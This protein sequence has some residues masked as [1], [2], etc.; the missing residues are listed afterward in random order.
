VLRQNNAYKSTETRNTLPLQNKVTNSKI[1][2][3][4][5]LKNKAS[6]INNTISII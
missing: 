6:V 5:I 4:S 3:L 1:I 2:M